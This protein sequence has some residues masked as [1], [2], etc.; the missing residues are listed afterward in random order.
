MMMKS[1]QGLPGCHVIAMYSVPR[2]PTPEKLGRSYHNV[3]P[4]VAFCLVNSI[5]LLIAD[6]VAQS[7]QLSLSAH[8]LA[9]LRLNLAVT[10]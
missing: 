1:R 2:S 7:L 10:C 6:F 4:N 8:C 9:V 5:G 3:R